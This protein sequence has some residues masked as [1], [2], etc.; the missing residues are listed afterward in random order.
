MQL[1]EFILE[2]REDIIAEWVA[3]ARSTDPGKK[4]DKPSLR[5]HS[6]EILQATARDMMSTQ[7]ESQ[8]HEKSKGDRAPGAENQSIESISESHGLVRILQG[9][10][11]PE[12]VSEYRSLRASVLRLWGKTEYSRA[13][14]STEEISRFNESIDQSLY[15]A[16]L[17]F[18]NQAN[19][20]HRIFLA[21]LAHD[22]RNPLS[23]I[24]MGAKA[25][26]KVADS[27]MDHTIP[28]RMTASAE[29]MEKMIEDLLKFAGTEL[30]AELPIL[31]DEANLEI[32][33]RDAL[34]EVKAAH[35]ERELRLDSK[36][37]FN[38]CWDEARIRQSVSNLIGN[39]VDHGDR[40]T[41]ILLTLRDD[42]PEVVLAVQ[43]AGESITPKDIKVIFDPLVTAS[44]DILERK[45][46]SGGLGLGLY[47][48][49]SV[50]SAHGGR[51][52]VESS[53][54][55]TVFTVRLPRR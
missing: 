41:P 25:L 48:V 55:K 20:S 45:K 52:E 5:N 37:D 10:D 19:Y 49:N 12:V 1:A 36:G 6:E 30:G 2:N 43:N 9:F 44:A 27:G 32:L 51:I 23:A 4:M 3:F 39:A 42:G 8:K 40:E 53:G 14:T 15:Q 24:K 31:K 22:L 46:R 29:V 54:N 7:S 16:V 13:S 47:I 34:E 28:R 17:S 50:I 38:G 35:P 18:T 33:C 21:I 11:L 26:G